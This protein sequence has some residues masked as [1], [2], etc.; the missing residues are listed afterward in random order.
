MGKSIVIGGIYLVIL[1]IYVNRSSTKRKI[2]NFNDQE[3]FQRT[4][5]FKMLGK[6]FLTV[7]FFSPIIL[8][9]PL[10]FISQTKIID[11]YLAILVLIVICAIV[12]G[13]MYLTLTKIGT[14]EIENRKKT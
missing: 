4:E 12:T 9:C 2:L 14:G 10:F 5:K 7:G 11:G 3:L 13:M 8:I 1:M 6:I